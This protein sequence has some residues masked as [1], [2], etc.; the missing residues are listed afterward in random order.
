MIYIRIAAKNQLSGFATTE[1]QK[2]AK[3]IENNQDGKVVTL[4]QCTPDHFAGV[5]L[6]YSSTNVTDDTFIERLCILTNLWFS[7]SSNPD[8][9]VVRWTYLKYIATTVVIAT[10]S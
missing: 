2:L 7:S 6:L 1:A 3:G 10:A 5:F 4:K 8:V 9:D